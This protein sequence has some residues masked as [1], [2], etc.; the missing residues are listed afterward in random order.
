MTITTVPSAP[1]TVAVRRPRWLIPAAAATAGLCLAGFGAIGY[2]LGSDDH[3]T[4][5][6][7][8]VI[9]DHPEPYWVFQNRGPICDQAQRLVDHADAT[10]SDVIEATVVT[11]NASGDVTSVEGQMYLRGLLAGCVRY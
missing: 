1:P 11:F 5:A 9:Y 10:L 8:Y 7:G 4:P 3:P 6:A 2:W